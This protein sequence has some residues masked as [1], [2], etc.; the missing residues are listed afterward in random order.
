MENVSL[1]CIMREYNVCV[2]ENEKYILGIYY[3]KC[4]IKKISFGKVHQKFALYMHYWKRASEFDSLCRFDMLSLVCCYDDDDEAFTNQNSFSC[5]CVG[6][7][8]V[9]TFCFQPHTYM[10]MLT[11]YNYRIE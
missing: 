9:S 1:S 8:L 2:N 5:F 3:Q 11:L 10:L 7:F 6:T 4:I